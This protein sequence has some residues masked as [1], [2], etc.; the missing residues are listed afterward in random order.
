MKVVVLSGTG[1]VGHN[2]VKQ[3]TGRGHEVIVT[4]R[5][6][7]KSFPRDDRAFGL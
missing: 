4:S 5:G 1:W 2:T 7:N 6:V 3:L